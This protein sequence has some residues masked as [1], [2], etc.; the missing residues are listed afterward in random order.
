MK[1]SMLALVIATVGVV[2][3][4]SDNSSKETEAT[5]V[6]QVALANAGQAEI[7]AIAAQL[8]IKYELISNR[9]K[10][11]CD[12]ENTGG[13]CFEAKLT[14]T[15]KEDINVKGWQIY[16]SQ[17]APLH[18]YD[19]ED[20]LVEHLNGD[21]HRISLKDNFTGLKANESKEIVYRAG[22]WSMAESDVMPN[23]IV[24]AD[25][26]SPKVIASTKA[27]IDT[28][29]GLEVLP[30]VTPYTDHENHFKRSANDNTEWL[31]ASDFYNRNEKVAGAQVNI[32]TAIIPSP[33]QIIQPRIAGQLELST[34]LNVTL[35]NADKADVEAALNRLSSL[36]IKESNDGVNLKASIKEDESKAKGSYQLAVTTDGIQIEGVDAAG[37]FNAIQSLASLVKVGDTSIPFV[38]IIDEPLF[39]FRGVLVD[40]SR[41]FRSKEFILKLLDQMAAYKLNKLHFH[42]GDDEGWRLEIPGL[43]ELTDIGSKRCFDLNEENCLMPQLGA[44][45]DSSASV[46]GYYS[47]A[48]YTEILQAASARHIQVLPSLDM[49]GHAR[50]AIK[51]MEARYNKYMKLENVAM[52]EQYLLHDLEDKSEYS[53]VQFY[54]DN[55]INACRE[56]SYAFVEK[57][58]Q[59]VQKIHKDAGQPLTRYH[60]G[61]DETAG[62]WVESPL[63][64][65][66]IANNDQGITEVKQLG[67]YFVERVSNMIS[68]MGIEPAAWSDGLEHTRKENM[69]SVV[70]AN[71]WD[72]LPW[73]AHKKVHDLANRNWQVVISTPDVTYF[74]FPY[75]ADPKEHGYYWASRNTNT[76]KV[77]QFM[78]ENLPVHAEFWTDRENNPYVADDTPQAAKEVKESD[79]HGAHAPA[80]KAHLPLSEGRKFYGLQAQLWGEN[81][82][83]D[84]LAE[85][86]LFPRLIA[87][88]ERA[89]YLP[90]WA[91][92]YNYEGFKY[93]QETNTFTGDMR[94]ARDAEWARFANVLG[95]KEFAKLELANIH[96]RL[97]TVGAKIVDG[98]LHANTAFPGLVIEYKDGEQNWQVYQQ[99]VAINDIV[100]VRA[101][102]HS[103]D[104]KGR[105]VTVN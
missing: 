55:T 39:E 1:K 98:K 65:E 49:P 104:R 57:V 28:D 43:P 96:Y 64:K 67:S 2:S 38:S 72:H 8:D 3:A 33:K 37:V 26:L 14:L 52:A 89:W 24:T 13:L 73:E 27:S 11:K 25:Q 94:K 91:V 80:T 90:T 60:I 97:P 101:S 54:G 21:M 93:S 53:S 41:N 62:A 29:T 56:S 86:K 87:L 42:L 7:D 36:G 30:F 66:F 63:C 51:A 40:T 32:D 5:S 79:S 70:Q 105:I 61:A 47:V 88:A 82:R 59:E 20:L 100:K 45:L 18:N 22:Y 58:M 77:F 95:Q 4:C 50:A 34:G 15:A 6:V 69:P 23:F 12:E 85:Y 99:P 17:I 46:N 68:E 31:T 74:D 35:S 76:E 78:P 75:E 92:P 83:S 81:L 44:G 9:Q 48:D 10:E 102:T 103:G 19:S 16:Y 71:A 84:A